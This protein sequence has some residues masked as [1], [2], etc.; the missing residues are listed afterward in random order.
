MSKAQQRVAL[1]TGCGSA[2]GIGFAAARALAQAGMAVALT[3]TTERIH[4][5]AAALEQ[6]GHTALGLVADLTDRSAAAGLIQVVV[7]RFGRL[8]VLVNNAGI[9]QV[10][11]PVENGCFVDI[12]PEQWARSLDVNLGTAFNVTHPAV[13]HLIAAGYGRIV[14]VSSVTGPYVVVPGDPGY[15]ASKAGMDGLT[16]ALAVELGAHGVTVNSVAPG[17]IDTGSSSEFELEAGR[18]TPLG[19]SGRPEEVAAAVAFLASEAA[20]YITGAVLVVDG[21]NIIQENKG[22]RG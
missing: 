21:G 8:D 9:G 14:N 22:P 3:S 17:W 10:G 18:Y 12:T 1:I 16:R 5:R 19:R 6:E 20:S 4:E 11:V 7:D 2:E 15:A 13:P